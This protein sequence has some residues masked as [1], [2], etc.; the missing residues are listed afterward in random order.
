MAFYSETLGV[1][2]E[3]LLAQLLLRAGLSGDLLTQQEQVYEDR[4]FGLEHD[5]IDRLEH[6][7]DRA[8]R[9]ATHQVLGF[10]V[11]RGQE[12]DRNARCLR[13]FPNERGCFVAV[14]LGHEDIEQ[15]DREIVLQQ[16]AQGPRT[17]IG[18]HHVRKRFEHLGKGQQ[19]PLVVVDQ[20]DAGSLPFTAFGYGGNLAHVATRVE[21]TEVST[22]AFARPIHTRSNASSRSMSTG[23]AM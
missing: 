20:Q 18:S 15:D 16:L 6:V 21:V 23:L 19:V 3:L 5:R 7:I 10:L 8:H 22:F 14:H 9:V 2:S 1:R 13:A 4:D 12:D 11:H 17:G